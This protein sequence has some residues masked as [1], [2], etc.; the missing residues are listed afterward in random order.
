MLVWM[1]MKVS[2]PDEGKLF[3]IHARIQSQAGVLSKW[4][5]DQAEH[6]GDAHKHCRKNNLEKK[7]QDN[8]FKL[9]RLRINTSMQENFK[10]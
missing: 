10:C 4:R 8:L 6:Q 2:L 5:N 9:K 1:S 7:H 3:S